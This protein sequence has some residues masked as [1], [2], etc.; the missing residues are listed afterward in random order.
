MLGGDAGV[1]EKSDFS[2]IKSWLE[3]YK[4]EQ[5]FSKKCRKLKCVTVRHRQAFL[6]K[7]YRSKARLDPFQVL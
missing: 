6:K 7:L 1:D 5:G 2:R 3:K 4:S